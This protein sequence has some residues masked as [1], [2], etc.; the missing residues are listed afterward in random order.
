MEKRW[1]KKPKKIIALVTGDGSAPE[2]M[3]VACAVVVE[4]AKKDDIKIIFEETPMGWNAYPKFG[5]T[6]PAASFQRAIE[7]GTIFFG[8]VGDPQFDNTVGAEKP[9]MKP[10][11]RCLLALRK[12][13][14]LLLNFR[15]MVYLKALAHLANVRQENIPDEGVEQVY[16]RF[17]LEDSYFGTPDLA[18]EVGEDICVKLGIKMKGDV[19]GDEGMIT[20][21]AY[22]RKET[23]EKYFRAAFAYARAK[24]LPLISIDKANVMPRYDFWRKIATR[25]GEEEFPDIKLVH[26]LVDSANALLFTPA[27]LRGVIVC[28]NEH[29]DILSDGAAA[30]LG[31]M[32]LMCSSAINPDTGAAMFESG[33][34]TAPTLAG[35]NIANPLGRILTGAM[36]LRHI[37]AIK[38][39]TAIEE[40]VTAVL[41]NGYR[42][43]DLVLG[44]EQSEAILGTKEMGDEVLSC[45]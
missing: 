5:D 39:A 10:E 11:A 28:G 13:M 3:K 14:R 40:A 24:G 16:I 19:V 2:M 38:G 30:A 25:I 44:D 23:I 1:K 22:Y 9:E 18:G 45:L 34:G 43:R 41:I 17:L 37:G 4:A 15:P 6:L 33:A 26:Q 31:S 36:M 20:E 21:L 32:G 7:L 12:E 29:G 27:K 8:G 42:T 35:K